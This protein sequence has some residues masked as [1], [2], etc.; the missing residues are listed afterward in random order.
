MG[1]GIAQVVVTPQVQQ[2]NFTLLDKA[3]LQLQQYTFPDGK[4]PFNNPLFGRIEF[5]VNYSG[6]VTW[7][8]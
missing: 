7:I 3:L 1:G 5:Q 2:S 4:R 8:E 6:V